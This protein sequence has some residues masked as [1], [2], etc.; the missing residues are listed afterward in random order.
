MD[1]RNQTVVVRVSGIPEPAVKAGQYRQR[2]FLEL[3][4]ARSLIHAFYCVGDDR[5]LHGRTEMGIGLADDISGEKIGLLLHLPEYDVG[6]EAVGLSP[7]H[8]RPQFG[9]GLVYVKME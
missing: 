1:H 4:V 9:L 6:H 2:R 3:L 8:Q 7:T 5:R